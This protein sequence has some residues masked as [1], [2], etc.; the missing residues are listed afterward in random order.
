MACTTGFV[1]KGL[2][3]Y[4]LGL[5]FLPHVPFLDEVLDRHD[6]QDSPPF[7]QLSFSSGYDRVFCIHE[8]L[9]R[10]DEFCHGLE[11]FLVKF[12]DEEIGINPIVEC[13]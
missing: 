7:F 2:L 8:V 3:S 11:L 13:C 9:S 6:V 5:S 4:C 12:V 1:L 10:M